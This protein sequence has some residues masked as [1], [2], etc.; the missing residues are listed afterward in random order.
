MDRFVELVPKYDTT[1][2]RKVVAPEVGEV[3]VVQGDSVEI[4]RGGGAR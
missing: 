2:K 1:G 4:E 3:L